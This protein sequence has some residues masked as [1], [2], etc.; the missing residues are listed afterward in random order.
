MSKNVLFVCFVVISM[1][2]SL[3]IGSLFLV[4]TI[5]DYNTVKTNCIVTNTSIDYKIY[6]DEKCYYALIYFNSTINRQANIPTTCICASQGKA[7]RYVA[8]YFPIGKIYPC[9]V[10]NKSVTFSEPNKIMN[11]VM[12]TILFLLSAFILFGSISLCLIKKR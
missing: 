8:Q 12:T 4:N 9:Y 6:E 5:D 1:G 2:A 7:E 3:G 11:L 10:F